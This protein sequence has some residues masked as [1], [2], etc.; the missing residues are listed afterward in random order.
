MISWE[1]RYLDLI[2]GKQTGLISSLVRS[3]LHLMSFFYWIVISARNT[4]YNC[5]WLKK[6][7]PSH[8][9]IVSIGNLV[10]GGTGKTPVT[11]T[12]AKEFEGLHPLAILTRGYRT[13]DEAKLLTERLPGAKVIVGKDRCKSADAAINSGHHLILLDDGF[14]HRKL[15]RDYDILVV[16]GRDPFSQGHLLPRGLLREPPSSFARADL[17]IINHIKDAKHFE[18][19]KNSISPYTKAPQIGAR[20]EVANIYDLQGNVAHNLKGK[21]VGLFCGIARPEYF[22][23]TVKDLG[24]QIVNSHFL[25]DHVAWKENDFH[26]FIKHCLEKGA[27]MIICTEKDKV[28]IDSQHI[29]DLPIIWLQMELKI[30]EGKSLWNTFIKNIINK[31]NQ[32]P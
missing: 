19:V 27:E 2:R 10:A 12:L 20:L 3:A 23:E 7:K 32:T 31:M 21:K 8:T 9:T 30:I 14:Q 29:F 5:G 4:A 22:V 24:A 26:D 18:S 25:S 15:Q 6:Y 1:N 28:K 11:I 13:G 16:D 17:I